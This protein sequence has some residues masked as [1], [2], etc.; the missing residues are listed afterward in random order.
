MRAKDAYINEF[1]S[2]HKTRF[3]IPIYQRNYD[4]SQEQCEDLFDDILKAGNSNK[5]HFIGNIVLYPHEDN[6]TSGIKELIIIDGQQR[7]TTITLMCLAIHRLGK[8]LHNNEIVDDMNAYLINKHGLEKG[9]LKLRA[10]ENDQA[11]ECLL[12]NEDYPNFSNLIENFNYFKNKITEQNY[13]VILD[14]LSKLVFV[15]IELEKKNDDPQRIF[16]S[17]NSKGLPLSQADLIRNY[18]LME[19]DEENQK[20][21]YTNYWEVI[22][23]LAKKE[24]ANENMVSEYIRHYLTLVNKKTPTKKRVYAEFKEKYR[25]PSSL[26]ELENHLRKIR[27]FAQYYN[28][29]INPN[30]ETDAEIQQQLKYINRLDIA[31]TLP[32]LMQVYADYDSSRIEKSVFVEIL[33]LLQSFFLRRSVVE[34]PTQ[35]LNLFFMNFYG[36]VNRDNYLGSIQKSLVQ[37]DI[38]KFPT[39]KEI[40]EVLKSRDIYKM[41]KSR[42]FLLERLENFENQEEVLIEN[43]PQITIEHIFPQTPDPEWQLELGQDECNRIK[44]QYLHT[45]GNLTLSGNNNK[46]GNKTFKEKR[47]LKGKGYKDSRLWLNQSLADLEKWDCEEIE[48]R[49][50][51]LTERFLKIWKRPETKKPTDEVQEKKDTFMEY[52]RIFKE[53]PL[54]RLFNRVNKDYASSQIHK[55]VFLKVLELL[56]SFLARKY[57]LSSPINF[58]EHKMDEIYNAIEKDNYLGSFKEVWLEQTG[59]LR[60]PTNDEVAEAL[61]TKGFSKKTERIRFFFKQ[62]KN[63]EEGIDPEKMDREEL[64]QRI[65]EIYPYP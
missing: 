28:K 13:Q 6:F 2:S 25:L 35:G 36:K 30:K 12:N 16:E 58:Q 59:S 44:E 40:I 62:L 34:V 63:D 55:S 15:E 41:K 10:T 21:V 60:F 8:T 11:L 29:L 52:I 65:L 46:L 5:T 49:C 23:T 51:S 26:E 4:W 37:N 20:S 27:K 9:K 17:L 39:D 33:E 64:T 22:E 19:L 7:I 3:R 42:N 53:N 43:N 57:I 54:L 24:D 56:Q 1:L 47:D 38:Y 14:G 61:K 31:F 18:I 50:E 48:K 32:F 45:L